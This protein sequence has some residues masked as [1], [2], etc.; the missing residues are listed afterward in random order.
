V[1]ARFVLIHGF[2]AVEDWMRGVLHL[3]GALLLFAAM[4]GCSSGPPE[5]ETRTWTEDVLLEDGSTLLVKR[6]ATFEVFR[7]WS[8]DASNAVEIEATLAFTGKLAQL[9]TWRQPLMALV[10]Y[11]DHGPDDWVVVASS[12]DCEVWWARGKPKPPYWEFRLRADGWHETPLSP[13]SMGRPANLFHRYQGE[14]KFDHITPAVRAR[15]ERPETMVRSYREVWGDVDQP[16]CGEGNPR[17]L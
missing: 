1:D 6:T 11:H 10:L 3:F 17:K 2:V 13:A 8:G 4:H 9:P 5:P 12:L 15:L 7:S 16:V 14:R